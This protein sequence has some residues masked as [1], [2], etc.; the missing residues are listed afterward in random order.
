[1]NFGRSGKGFGKLGSSVKASSG[2]GSPP[3]SPGVGNPIGLLL[4]LTYPA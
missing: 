2:G 1:M 4:V 3:P